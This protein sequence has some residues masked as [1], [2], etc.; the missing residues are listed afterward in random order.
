MYL[1]DVLLITVRSGNGT[2]RDE[3]DQH[4]SSATRELGS[5]IDASK[6]LLLE[7]M[8]ACP[9]HF[10]TSRRI[11]AASVRKIESVKP[12]E[13]GDLNLNERLCM[14]SVNYLNASAPS[15]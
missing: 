13:R 4:E 7:C 2:A 14:N 12:V 11:Y 10:T 3:C 6:C 9:L 5:R 1:K 8:S 15:L